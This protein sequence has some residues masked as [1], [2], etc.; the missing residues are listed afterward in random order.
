MKIV[1]AQ[2]F[3]TTAVIDDPGSTL[4]SSYYPGASSSSASH[5][6]RVLAAYGTPADE[7]AG[8]RRKATQQSAGPAAVQK[9]FCICILLAPGA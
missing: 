2:S 1:Q 5:D 8:T 6:T 4:L 7:R 3:R 9:A